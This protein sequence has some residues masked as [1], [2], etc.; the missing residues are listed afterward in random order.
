M[1]DNPLIVDES[2]FSPKMIH[3]STRD[4]VLS[5][6]LMSKLGKRC[7]YWDNVVRIIILRKKS[8]LFQQKKRKKKCLPTYSN[9]EFEK[10]GTKI[11]F[12]HGL[13]ISFRMNTSFP[14]NQHKGETCLWYTTFFWP[15]PAIPRVFLYFG[16]YK[17]EIEFS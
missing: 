7:S 4:C 15:A 3:Q 16:S 10:M 5:C 8:L 12:Y 17:Y 6:S 14:K 2:L 9:F 1:T 13:N 11:F